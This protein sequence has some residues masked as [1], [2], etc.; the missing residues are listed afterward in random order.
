[1]M[2]LSRISLTTPW[3]AASLVLYFLGGTCWLPVVWLR[4]RMHRLASEALTMNELLPPV[5]YRYA[6]LWFILGWPTFIS[7]LTIFWLMVAKPDLWREGHERS[8]QPPDRSL[9]TRE[10]GRGGQGGACHTA[11]DT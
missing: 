8:S 4:I 11:R 5:I 1:M 3:I 6:K 2:W 10:D 7:V 9:K